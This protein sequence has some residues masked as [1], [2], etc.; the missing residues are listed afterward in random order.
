VGFTI[1]K[2]IERDRLFDQGL[3]Y[4]P[5]CKEIKP[6]CAFSKRSGVPTGRQI[7][8]RV[9]TS[10]WGQIHRERNMARC[11]EYR[12]R[13]LDDRRAYDRQYYREHRQAENARSRSY[14][15]TDK[16]RLAKRRGGQ[17]RRARNISLR[18]TL[19]ED[20]WQAAL[21]FFDN[22]CAYCGVSGVT[23]A[24]EHVVSLTA[25]GGYVVDNI[26]PACERCNSSKNNMPL[27]KW[28]TGRGLAFMRDDA[29]ER[30]RAYLKRLE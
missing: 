10:T 28:A 1:A 21:E 17:K 22:R 30:V 11:R 26:V 24:Q 3:K 2:R 23:L 12:R 15:K 27:D 29:V 5:R 9:C 4:C 14:G 20:Q 25:G 16:G 13:H 7:W 18:A 6:L 19:T 8:C